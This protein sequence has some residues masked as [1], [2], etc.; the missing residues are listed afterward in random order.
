MPTLESENLSVDFAKSLVGNG[1]FVILAQ[2][3]EGKSTFALALIKLCLDRRLYARYHLVLPAFRYE[4]D[5]KYDW[6]KSIKGVSIYSMYDDIIAERIVKEAETDVKKHGRPLPVFFFGDDMTSARSL[7]YLP[8]GTVSPTVKLISLCRHVHCTLVLAL[9]SKNDIIHP[10]IVES[11]S[12]LIL[13]TVGSFQTLHSVWKSW[14]SLECTWEEFRALYRA[15]VNRPGHNMLGLYVG[16]TKKID[17]GV[18]SWPM[19]K[20][21]IDQVLDKKNDR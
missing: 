8:G 7:R 19:I 1:L 18:L 10:A 17:D 4:R 14:F 13:G 6:L 3:G 20:T 9:H 21:R 5:L 2:R 15:H 11:V 16:R 12:W